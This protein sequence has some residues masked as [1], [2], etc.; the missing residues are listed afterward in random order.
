[1]LDFLT[2]AGNKCIALVRKSSFSKTQ[3]RVLG[4]FSKIRLASSLKSEHFCVTPISIRLVSIRLRKNVNF[5]FLVRASGPCPHTID[6]R[7]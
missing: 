7:P 6:I 3:L 2:S 4:Y 5:R 1:M